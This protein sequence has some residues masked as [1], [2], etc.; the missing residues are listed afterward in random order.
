MKKYLLVFFICLCLLVFYG[1]SVFKKDK[2]ADFEKPEI[3]SV[4]IIGQIKYPGTYNVEKNTSLRKLIYYAGGLLGDADVSMFD[5][6]VVVADNKTYYIQKRSLENKINI[7]TATLE[8]LMS[9]PNIGKVKAEEIINY[10]LSNGFF[11]SVD[12]LVLIKGIGQKIYEQIRPFIT[13]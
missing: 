11:K 12:E 5:L 3:V 10:R 9:L 1:F 6:E 7:N 8:E 4:A 13:V 2:V